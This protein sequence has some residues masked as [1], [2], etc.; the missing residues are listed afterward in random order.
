MGVTKKEIIECTCDVCDNPC[1]QYESRF[2][3]QINGGDGRD[4][5]PS[6]IRGLITVEHPYRCSSGVVCKKCQKE[7][8]QRYINTLGE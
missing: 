5:G 6:K 4:V 2:E 3:I 1:D 8:L 7:W